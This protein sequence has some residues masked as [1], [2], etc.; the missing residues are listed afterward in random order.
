MQ[1]LTTAEPDDT[2]LEVAIV[3]LRRVL[4]ADGVDVEQ[5]AEQRS[6]LVVPV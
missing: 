2:Q 6:A 4:A 1:K 5:D 3:A